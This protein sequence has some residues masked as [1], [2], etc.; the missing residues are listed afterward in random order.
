VLLNVIENP[1]VSGGE[2]LAPATTG[3][4]VAS[5]EIGRPISRDARGDQTSP[6]RRFNP[7]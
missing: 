2:M 3:D 7:G 4:V 6:P 5:G 1:F